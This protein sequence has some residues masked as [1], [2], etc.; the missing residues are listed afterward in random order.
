[1]FNHQHTIFFTSTSLL[2]CSISNFTLIYISLFHSKQIQGAYRR[3]VVMFSA[4]GFLFSLSEFIAR[5]FAHNYNR[6]LILFSINDWISSKSFLEIAISV[7]MTFYLLIISFIGIQFLYRYICLFHSAKVRYFDGFGTVL[8]ISY[9]LIPAAGFNIAFYQLLKPTDT[10]DDY[11]RKVIR[12]NYDLE[13]SAIARY[14]L[15]LYSESNVIQWEILS[16]II[17]AGIVLCFQYFIV[18]FFGVKLHFKI[19]EKLGTF[20]PCQVKIQ[21]QI[22]RALVAQTVGPTLFLVLPSAPFFLTTLLSPYIDMEINWKTGWLYTLIGIYPIF[23]SIAFILIVSEYRNYV[24]SKLFCKTNKSPR[25]FGNK[26]SIHPI[27]CINTEIVS[28]T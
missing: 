5:P 25:E 18:I 17:A 9:L 6:A 15:A 26:I 2:I 4:L 20:S 21:S 23:D 12:E 28:D 16:L 13:I 11:L 14:T 8:W 1:M 7:W 3:M 24:R 22:F 19:K 10:S 27:R